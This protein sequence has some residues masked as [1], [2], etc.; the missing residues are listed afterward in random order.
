[1][2]CC[3]H[4]P[5]AHPHLRRRVFTM[6]EAGAILGMSR[7]TVRKEI[8]AGRLAA[9][10]RMVRGDKKGRWKISDK[11]IEGWIDKNA[12]HNREDLLR[13]L[14]ARRGPRQT[15]PQGRA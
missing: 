1:M 10:P 11:A 9:T 15:M 14:D 3:A 5:V 6:S 4:C 13:A 7:W 12:V 8:L 2:T